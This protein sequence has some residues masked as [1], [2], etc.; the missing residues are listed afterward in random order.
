[1]RLMLPLSGCVKWSHFSFLYI[2]F[3]HTLNQH[4][5]VLFVTV[6]LSQA[7]TVIHVFYPRTCWIERESVVYL[8]LHIITCK[9]LSIV[10]LTVTKILS[11][12]PKNLI[13]IMLWIYRFL[14]TLSIGNNCLL[15]AGQNVQIS[16][17]PGGNTPKLPC[18]SL[19]FLQVMKALSPA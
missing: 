16:H 6:C 4:C 17:L 3:P 9:K 13:S 18:P 12:F 2:L 15:Y 19:T 7:E 14:S 8:G 5:P 10:I 11:L 1:M